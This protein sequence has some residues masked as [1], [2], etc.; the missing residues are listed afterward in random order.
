MLSFK[1]KTLSSKLL[2]FYG[3]K[4]Q[5]KS[6]F[7]WLN[8]GARIHLLSLARVVYCVFM[9]HLFIRATWLS[10][11]I[12]GRCQF[13]QFF[14]IQRGWGLFWQHSHKIRS[15]WEKFKLSSLSGHSSHT[16]ARR[17]KLM[18]YLWNFLKI[19]LETM[20]RTEHKISLGVDI[21]AKMALT[22]REK[23]TL[24]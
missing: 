12:W 7:S 21:N 15:W 5:I 14:F 22:S 16:V 1:V 18:Q 23:M 6:K 24:Y 4:W 19:Y 17:R 10:R 2:T 3:S 13:L 11:I 9:M 8:H 20:A